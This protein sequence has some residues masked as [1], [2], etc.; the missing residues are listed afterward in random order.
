MSTMIARHDRASRI[1]LAADRFAYLVVSYG[2]LLCVAY[3]S[4]VRDEASWDLIGLVVLGGICGLAY[5]ARRGVA[6]GRSTA[7]L[8]G[9]AGIAA[10]I[11]GSLVLMGR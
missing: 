2:L 10:V 5:R 7:V 11:A 6:S 8:L 1:E 3:R 9:T 4:F